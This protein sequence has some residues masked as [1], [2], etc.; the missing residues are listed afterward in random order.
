MKRG[1]LRLVTHNA[2]LIIEN[3]TAVRLEER[4]ERRRSASQ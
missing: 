2:A 1:E 4:D 3:G